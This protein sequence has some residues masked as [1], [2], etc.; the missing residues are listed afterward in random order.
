MMLGDTKTS[1]VREI[2]FDHY[3]SGLIGY[4]CRPRT[5]LLIFNNKSVFVPFI[6]IL[7]VNTRH[8]SQNKF[9]KVDKKHF[10]YATDLFVSFRFGFSICCLTTCWHVFSQGL[11]SY[12]FQPQVVVPELELCYLL[13]CNHKSVVLILNESLLLIDFLIA[14][15][16][17]LRSFEL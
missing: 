3:T 11:S 5:E 13:I 15:L 9:T 8:W 10:G 4:F 1:L 17:L 6:G 16:F 2:F 12:P 14:S 7:V